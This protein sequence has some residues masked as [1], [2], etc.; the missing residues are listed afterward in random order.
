MEILRQRKLLLD[1]EWTANAPRKG[2]EAKLFTD[3]YLTVRNF[4]RK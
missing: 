1:S 3:N 4:L 2:K